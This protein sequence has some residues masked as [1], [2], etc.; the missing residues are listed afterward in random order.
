MTTD[1]T[2]LLPSVLPPRDSRDTLGA[3]LLRQLQLPALETLFLRMEPA[4][5]GD[6]E[7]HDDAYLLSVPHERWLAQAAGVPLDHPGL[8]TGPY[9]RLAAQSLSDAPK[10]ASTSAHAQ[11]IW[12][13][14]QPVHIHAAR[15]HLVM[16]DP[17][18]LDIRTDE[19]D[20]LYAAIEPLL[21]EYG[22]KVER[23]LPAYW[24]LAD[25]PFGELAAAPPVRAVGRNIELWMQRG[26]RAR[27][28]R[29]FQ[30]EVQMLWFDHPVNQVREAEGRLPINSVWLY[31]AGALQQVAP[32][33]D[34]VWSDDLLT[35]GLALAS[36]RSAFSP[37]NALPDNLPSGHT[38][39]RL[40]HASSSYTN[41]DWANWLEAVRHLE[42]HW[43]APALDAMQQGRLSSLRLVLTN[44]THMATRI[45]TRSGLRKFWR[46]WRG[47][48]RQRW[49]AMGGPQ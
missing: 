9:L 1:L 25:Q 28:W 11:A 5:P 34:T 14:L 35:R 41:G 13:C 33:A 3:D 16:V 22:L 6:D 38:L 42:T 26:E 48:W 30:N 47:D 49:L 32:F 19:A 24:F 43:F 18:A 15:D 4:G 31:G 29:R 39:A 7:T 40:E 12:A 10:D 36:G 2:L 44:D 21:V 20:S 27:E 17:A 23:S 45:I 8:P 37:P 46:A